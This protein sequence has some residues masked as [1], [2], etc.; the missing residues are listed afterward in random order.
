MG[1]FIY[2]AVRNDDTGIYQPPWEQWLRQHFPNWAFV[3]LD[4]RSDPSFLSYIQQATKEHNR[5]IVMIELKTSSNAPL[6]SAST[7]LQRLAREQPS[8]T[9]FLLQ[10]EHPSLKKMGKA[11]RL[12]HQ[13]NSQEEMEQR[14]KQ[15]LEIN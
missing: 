6:G 11:F 14:L 15:V 8:E 2:A 4:N 9:V 13:T 10:G 7:L 1:L 3:D 12:F 5:I